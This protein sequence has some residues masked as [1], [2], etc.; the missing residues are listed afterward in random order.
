MPSVTTGTAINS[1]Y[2]NM[3]NIIYDGNALYRAFCRTRKVCAYK[4]QMQ[5][6]ELDF[7]HQLAVLQQ[8]LKSGE[9]EMMP[10]TQFVIKERGKQG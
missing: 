5:R 9:Y 1:R 6:F 8:E 2:K 3:T 10:K 4:P 7:L